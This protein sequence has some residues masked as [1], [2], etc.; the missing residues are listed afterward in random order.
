MW[1][2]EAIVCRVSL[3]KT[4]PAFCSGHGL[5]L[6]PLQLSQQAWIRFDP[7]RCRVL[8]MGSPRRRLLGRVHDKKVKGHPAITIEVKSW[9]VATNPSHMHIR[10]DMQAEADRQWHLHELP[11][12]GLQAQ[13]CKNE[14]WYRSLGWSGIGRRYTTL[15]GPLVRT[16]VNQKHEQRQVVGT[17]AVFDLKTALSS[18]HKP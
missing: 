9:V 12:C 3:G 2:N 11:N 16:L 6:S 10:V 8:S 4:F 18:V 7:Q 17:C 14:A 15:S 1:D 13:H 5:S